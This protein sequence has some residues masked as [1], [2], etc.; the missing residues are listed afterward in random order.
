MRKAD[1]YLG[2][3]TSPLPVYSRTRTVTVR[4][5]V[6]EGKYYVCFECDC[7]YFI[8]EQCLCRHVYRVVDMKPSHRHVFPEC[9]K[10]YETHTSGNFEVLSQCRNLTDTFLKYNGLVLP[11]RLEDVKFNVGGNLAS[12]KSMDWF[13]DAQNRLIDMNYGNDEYELHDNINAVFD[14]ES[15]EDQLLCDL[16]PKKTPSIPKS[17]KSSVFHTYLSE[18]SDVCNHVIESNKDH[19]EIR[20]IFEECFSSCRS[21]ILRFQK[22]WGDNSKGSGAAS[23]RAIETSS[24]RKRK[25]PMGSPSKYKS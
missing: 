6:M 11:G 21:Q 2:D 16:A 25:A 15:S 9:L 17:K 10:V 14:D 19:P 24:K 13:E 8:R 1:Y 22:G 20:R 3:S 7:F 5:I 4:Q 18:Y 23:F 12:K